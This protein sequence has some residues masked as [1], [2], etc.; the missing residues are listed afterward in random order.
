MM[1]DQDLIKLGQAYM[2]AAC[3]GTLTEAVAAMRA[4]L[5]Q[6]APEAVPVAQDW[7]LRSRVADL[8]H[9]LE[10]SSITSATGTDDVQAR[11]VMADLRRMLS[12]TVAQ[13]GAEP[14]KPDGKLHVDGYFTWYR[15]DGYV[16]DRRLPCDFYLAPPAAHAQQPAALTDAQDAARWRWLRDRLLAG[17][18]DYGGEGI[19]ALVFEMPAGFTVSADADAVVD[20]AMRLA[21][22]QAPTTD[23]GEQQ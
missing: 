11:K 15:R 22:A 1:T 3:T 21:A 18:F 10:F 17:D 23:T 4:A 16:M 13:Q 6:Q 12:A 2:A 8:L 14:P 19:Q 7:L 20:D 5:S 9:L